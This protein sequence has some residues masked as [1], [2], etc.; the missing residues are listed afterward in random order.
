MLTLAQAYHLRNAA[1]R[2]TSKDLDCRVLYFSVQPW[3]QSVTCGDVNRHAG[4][5]LKKVLDVD[6]V[7]HAEVDFAVIV[8]EDV[9]I[10]ARYGVAAGCCSKVLNRCDPKFPERVS[11]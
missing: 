10:T 7:K 8:H 1:I 6:E 3:M 9:D 11:I 4:S 5:I 2:V